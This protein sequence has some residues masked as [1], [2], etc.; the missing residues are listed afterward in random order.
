MVMVPEALM[1]RR[2]TL[3]DYLS[4]P[5][6]QRYE[7]IDGVLYVASR[8][9]APHQLAAV[10]L[11]FDLVAHVMRPGLGLVLP[12][13]DLI[14]DE[15]GTYLAP[16]I[17]VFL[18]DRAAGLVINERIQTI[19]DL[20]VEVISPSSY[21]YD[22]VTKR[23]TYARLGVHH[24][25]IADPGNGVLHELVLGQD[26]RYQAREIRTPDLFRPALFPDLAIEL[27]RVFAQR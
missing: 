3:D 25:W 19:P 4:L 8:P 16:D 27:A 10:N 1:R 23:D 17:M 22:H 13:A 12:D 7:I 20:I 21:T 24:Y 18:G 11:A 26:G 2:L 9:F 15:L 14:V 5:N 6:D